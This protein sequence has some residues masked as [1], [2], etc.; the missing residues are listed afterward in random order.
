MLARATFGTTPFYYLVQVATA[1][2]LILAA[3]TS[4]A[5]FP[6]L[7][8]I[9]ARDRFLP[10]QLSNQGDRLV[11]SNGILIL[12]ILASALLVLFGGNTH[13]LIPLYAVGVFLSFTL[14]QAGMVKRWHRLGGSHW[15]HQA[16]VNGLG[17]VTT[18][19]AVAVIGATKFTHGAWIVILLIPCIVAAFLAVHRHYGE[20]AEQLSLEHLEPRRLRRHAVLVIASGIHRGVLDALNYARAISPDVQAVTVDLDTTATA[21]LRVKWR[22]WVPDIPLVVLESPYR[23]VLEPLRTYIDKVQEG[24]GTEMITLILPEFVPRRW[25]HHLLYNQTALLIKGAFLFRPGTI[26]TSVP[27]H[28]KM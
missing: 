6:R 16:A 28:L 26:V 11:F 2:I 15:W 20:I 3:N 8:S 22:E 23:S 14:S 13:A 1:L 18:G 25:W 4:Y 10:R 17:A 24:E 27:H 5:D 12:G 19:L 9:I 7:S 21:K